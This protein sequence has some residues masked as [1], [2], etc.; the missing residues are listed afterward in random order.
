MGALNLSNIDYHIPSLSHLSVTLHITSVFLLVESKSSF[1][2]HQGKR[3]RLGVRSRQAAD[4]QKNRCK[5]DQ[6]RYGRVRGQLN[7]HYPVKVRVS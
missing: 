1:R 2:S 4:E 5:C 7:S 3:S 6:K